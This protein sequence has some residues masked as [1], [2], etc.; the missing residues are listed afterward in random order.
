MGRY[1]GRMT[2][3]TRDLQFP[4]QICLPTHQCRGDNYQRVNQL[5]NTLSSVPGHQYCDNDVWHQVFCFQEKAH[6]E[7]FKAEIGGEWF[8]PRRRGRGTKWHLLRDPVT[9]KY[10]SPEEILKLKRG[11]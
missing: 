2:A 3:N 11:S 10:P 4:H 8:D 7:T 6:A 9:K 5:A 1:K